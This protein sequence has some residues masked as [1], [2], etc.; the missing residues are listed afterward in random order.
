MVKI[1]ML[2]FELIVK[3]LRFSL[4]MMMMMIIRM[5]NIGDGGREVSNGNVAGWMFLQIIR[6][7]W[8]PYTSLVH[9]TALRFFP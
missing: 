4:V 2:A 3:K 9:M 6:H 8:K 7:V 5:P 1:L